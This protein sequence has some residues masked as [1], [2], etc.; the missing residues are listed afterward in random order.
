MERKTAKEIVHD[1]QSGGVE[2]K[3]LFISQRGSKMPIIHDK[4]PARERLHY[5]QSLG[6]TEEE[7]NYNMSKYYSLTEEQIEALKCE[8]N[9]GGQ[10]TISH[11]RKQGGKRR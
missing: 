6:F 7:I 4:P 10:L 3:E 8:L 1:Y 5:L 11:F 2:P 9:E